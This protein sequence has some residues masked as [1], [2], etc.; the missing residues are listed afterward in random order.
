MSMTDGT[1]PDSTPGNGACC[2]VT[3]DDETQTVIE[4]TGNF[5]G[6]TDNAEN[7]S[8]GLS[9]DAYP[10][11]AREV[12]TVDLTQNTAQIVTSRITDI[13]GRVHFVQENEAVRGMQHNV[14]S[15]AHFAP[16]IYLLTAENEEER[17]TRR[18]VKM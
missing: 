3:E 13:H 6:N 9:F 15:T 8:G 2:A 4:V 5:T 10:V 11:P 14:I 12:L 16:G 18:F 7:L 17:V 1:D